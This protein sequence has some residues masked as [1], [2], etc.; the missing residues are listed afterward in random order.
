M[1]TKYEEQEVIEPVK[2]K[3][4]IVLIFNPIYTEKEI[5]EMI[6]N[7]DI[8]CNSF[9]TYK[10]FLGIKSL[11]YA[12]KGFTSGFYVILNAYNTYEEIKQMEILIRNEDK[13]LKY[14]IIERN[15]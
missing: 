2:H 13:I 6:N 11:A 3:Y 12:V 9:L 14:I 5:D 7:M 8:K 4:E 1:L 10:E 15:E